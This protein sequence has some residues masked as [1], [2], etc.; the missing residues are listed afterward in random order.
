MVITFPRSIFTKAIGDNHN[1]I[2]CDKC[3]LWVNM[4]CNNLNF[5]DYQ[6]LNGND[7][8]W[9]C[10]KCNSELFPFGTLNNKTFTNTQTASTYRTK[11]M[12]MIILVT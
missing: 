11:T 7:D 10:L 1:Y 9:F 12:I 4:K 8:P 3:N 5:R 6:Y 2:Y